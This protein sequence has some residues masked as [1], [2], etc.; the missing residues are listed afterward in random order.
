MDVRCL[1]RQS[2]RAFDA[3]HWFSIYKEGLGKGFMLEKKEI[4]WNALKFCN[5]RR[6]EDHSYAKITECTHL[7]AL[8]HASW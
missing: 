6:F 8:S 2:E 3:I 7:P 4:T 5:S 1:S